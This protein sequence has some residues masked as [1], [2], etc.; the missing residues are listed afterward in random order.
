MKKQP[1]GSTL[2]GHD[3]QAT[4]LEQQRDEV[5]KR[6]A[7]FLVADQRF[8]ADVEYG[9]D[10]FEIGYPSEHGAIRV[11]LSIETDEEVVIIGKAIFPLE[12]E[13]ESW[14][15]LTEYADLINERISIGEFVVWEGDW[16][17]FTNHA[18]VV[19]SQTEAVVSR[20]L[21]GMIES[22]KWML[23]GF[24]D[25]ALGRGRPAT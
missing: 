15:A 4:V 14:S 16:V 2:A 24:G 3:E 22:V 10:W 18:V 8:C 11:V 5:R 19:P 9:Y 17:E 1:W 12:I 23:P 25:V 13:P 6:L 7:E 21:A 20:L